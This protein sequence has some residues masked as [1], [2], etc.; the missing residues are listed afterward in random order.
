MAFVS[1]SGNSDE[2]GNLSVLGPGYYDPFRKVDKSV[3]KKQPF[4]LSKQRFNNNFQATFNPG[5][6]IKVLGNTTISE[7]LAKSISIN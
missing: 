4:D 5:R 3:K 7:I 2:K 1:L 6:L